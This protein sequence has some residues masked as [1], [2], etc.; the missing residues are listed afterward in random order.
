MGLRPLFFFFWKMSNL[1]VRSA[2]NPNWKRIKDLR[3][4]CV[5]CKQMKALLC[6]GLCM[7]CYFKS[8]NF[9]GL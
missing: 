8:I 6:N 5:G 4:V 2:G 1:K 7:D 9:G 3:R